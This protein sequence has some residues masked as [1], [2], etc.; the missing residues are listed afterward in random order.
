MARNILN[1]ADG[2][3]TEDMMSFD[4]FLEFLANKDGEIIVMLG[5]FATSEREEDDDDLDT[6]EPFPMG[7][8]IKLSSKE[9]L[10]ATYPTIEELAS[11]LRNFNEDIGGWC[12][13]HV[14]REIKGDCV[15][16][17]PKTAPYI[18]A[19]YDRDDGVGEFCYN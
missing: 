10:L 19:V 6:I 14:I 16:A 18:M 8:F 15:Y 11:V 7:S 1:L 3:L 13:I 17:M 4:F 9:E 2:V 12:Q 5:Q